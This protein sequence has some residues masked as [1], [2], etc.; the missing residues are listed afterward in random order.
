MSSSSPQYRYNPEQFRQVFE[1]SSAT[2]PGCGATASASP[3]GRRCTIRSAAGAGP[4]RSSGR[5]PGRLAAGLY[6]RGV[7]RRG[8]DRLRPLQRSRVR[9]RLD[10]RAAP[11][12]VA[13]PINFRLA[14]GEVAH[15][16]DDSRPKVFILDSS[17]GDGRRRGAVDGRP[18]PRGR[19]AGR[20]RGLGPPVA[21][22]MPFGDAF[23][24]RRR[25]SSAEPERSIYAETT[26]LYTS[27]TTGCRRASRSPTWS[28]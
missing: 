12:A 15:V 13:T 7:A 5:T 20:S 28:R 2:S 27:G 10:R 18:P 21:A 19:I 8:R 16:L 3:R 26:R 17:L 9:A 4:T 14:A 1:Q 22:A 23:A 24:G 6:E 25:G 11:G